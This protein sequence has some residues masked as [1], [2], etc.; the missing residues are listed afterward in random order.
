MDIQKL[1][2]KI[3]SMSNSCLPL[4]MFLNDIRDNYYNENYDKEGA[5]RDIEKIADFINNQQ[6]Q[7]AILEKALELMAE[8]V[9]KTYLPS[10]LA[11]GYGCN[12]NYY[13]QQAEKELE[14]KAS[15]QRRLE[16]L[17]FKVGDEAIRRDCVKGKIV[18]ICTCE[19]CVERGFYEPSI[20]MED[21]TTECVTDYANEHNFENWYSIGNRVFGYLDRDGLVAEHERLAKETA[22]SETKIATY[23]SIVGEEMAIK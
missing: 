18:R 3:Y 13:K 7:I 2:E 21:G 14:K 22:L 1:E 16:E 5:Y 15:A 10:E 19:R 20:E 6:N 12:I 23:N 9:E 8:R 4:G 17:G 11:E